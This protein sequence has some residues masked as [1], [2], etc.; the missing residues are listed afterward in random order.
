MP[1]ADRMLPTLRRAIDFVK[2]TPGRSGH[3]VRLQNCTQVLVAGD[4]HGHVRNFQVILKAADLANHPTRHLVIQEVVHS[5]FVYPNGGDKSHQLLDLFAAL[6][7]QYPTRVH[8]LPGNHELA[9]WT[10]RSIGKGNESQNE[11]FR[12]GVTT[13]YGEAASEIYALYMEMLKALPIALRTP[14]DVFISHS[15]TPSRNMGTFDARAC[16]QTPPASQHARFAQGSFERR[17]MHVRER[18][19][20]Q[21]QVRTRAAHARQSPFDRNRIRLKE[22]VLMQRQQPRVDLARGR[23]IAFA[24]G[25]DHVMHEPGRDVRRH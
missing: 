16:C 11:A 2:T 5:A 13:A 14:N 4:L 12:Q 22:Q 3:L 7:C 20:R 19:H 6:K 1:P 18:R 23:D 25:G 10:N 21:P 17:M 8:L 15:L 24:R 9:Q